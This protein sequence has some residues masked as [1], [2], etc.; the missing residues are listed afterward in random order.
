MASALAIMLEAPLGAAGRNNE[1]GRPA[2]CGYFR[3]FELA[4]PG[5]TAIRGYHKPVMLAGGLG[6]IRPGH[7]HKRAVPRVP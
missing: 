2:L 4:L 7:T 3:T 6:N 5:E 1:F